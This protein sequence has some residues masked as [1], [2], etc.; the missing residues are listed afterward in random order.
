MNACILKALDITNGFDWSVL[1]CHD[2]ALALAS[3]IYNENLVWNFL[4]CHYSGT[5]CLK[6]FSN[7]NYYGSACYDYIADI[8]GLEL[9]RRVVLRDALI[10]ELLQCKLPCVL[11]IN[12]YYRRGSKHYNKKTHPH[13]VLICEMNA[14]TQKAKILDE[15]MEK[16]YWKTENFKDGVKYEFQDL[17]F[18]DVI[19]LTK[20]TDEFAK[21]MGFDFKMQTGNYAYFYV[22]HKI[23]DINLTPD[24]NLMSEYTNIVKSFDSHVQYLQNRLD[25]FLHKFEERYSD[26][27]K[28]DSE[29]LFELNVNDPTGIK[30]KLYFPYEWQLVDFHYR[31]LKRINICENYLFSTEDKRLMT[32]INR[33]EL[34]KMQLCLFIIKKSPAEIKNLIAKTGM[35]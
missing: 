27:P 3:S 30:A 11:V 31:F 22:I 21:E 19:T 13:F 34:I 20:E 17:P 18:D 10:D 4:M 33:Y 6:T 29:Y 8:S 16:Q 28:I 24:K 35:I 25:N 5:N 26:L 15:P 1:N 23:K 12:N 14:D 2:R 9:E 7:N 32:F